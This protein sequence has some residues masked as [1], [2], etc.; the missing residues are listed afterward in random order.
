MGDRS[1][2]QDKNI[3]IFPVRLD[4]SKDQRLCL[5]ISTG[6]LHKYFKLTLFKTDCPS[7]SSPS[8]RIL[9]LLNGITETK[10]RQLFLIPP[11]CIQFA[12]LLDSTSKTS[13][14]ST[15]FLLHYYHFSLSYFHPKTVFTLASFLS[16]HFIY[17]NQEIEHLH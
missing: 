10:S 7:D 6:W 8:Q 11:S 14:E 4:P 9:H 17:S 16:L 2:R 12:C 3:L 1:F 15:F 5:H 13:H